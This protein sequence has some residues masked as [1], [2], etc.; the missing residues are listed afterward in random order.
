MYCPKCGVQ[1]PDIS[2]FCSKCGIILP[3]FENNV[4]EANKNTINESK[5][6]DMSNNSVKQR[7]GFVTF[8]LIL[9]LLGNIFILYTQIFRESSPIDELLGLNHSFYTIQQFV[10]I[11]GVILL[12]LW[13]KIGFWVIVGVD[14]IAWIF[15]SNTT[16]L[17]LL[18]YV[19]KNFILFGILNISKNG[20]ST[21]KHLD[22]ESV[23][24][25]ERL[26]SFFDKKKERQ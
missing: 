7:N 1:L 12:L 14:F 5:N 19:I 10:Y 17:W 6:T 22:N 21:W 16:I 13:I 18:L 3:S 11:A 24:L 8:W 4:P 20:I 15:M 25:W 2:K 23:I 26:F 9:M